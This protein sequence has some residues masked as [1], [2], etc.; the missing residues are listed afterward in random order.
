MQPERSTPRGP[1]LVDT[2]RVIASSEDVFCRVSAFVRSNHNRNVWRKEDRTRLIAAANLVA[3]HV[4]RTA[5]VP[6]ADQILRLELNWLLDLQVVARCPTEA[7]LGLDAFVNRIRLAASTGRA[8]AALCA[9]DKC[10][11]GSTDP[12]QNGKD[13]L[14]HGIQLFTGLDRSRLLDLLG[15]EKAFIAWRSGKLSAMNDESANRLVDQCGDSWPQLQFELRLRLQLERATRTE[16]WLDSSDTLKRALHRALVYVDQIDP[17]PEELL[18]EIIPNGIERIDEMSFVCPSTAHLWARTAS[19]WLAL[20]AAEN[21]SIAEYAVSA[22]QANIA[23][24]AKRSLDHI[25]GPPSP[26]FISDGSS[27]GAEYAIMIIDLLR[28]LSRND[29]EVAA[30]A[31]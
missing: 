10:L 16:F 18:L 22:T 25:M 19:R 20:N 17:P 4:A 1:L 12:L 30:H 8:D 29:T 13:C 14:L 28:K 7:H 27:L 24:E 23:E 21:F 11:S 31:P 15:F 2:R 3:Y 26:N 5:G 9:I 6:L